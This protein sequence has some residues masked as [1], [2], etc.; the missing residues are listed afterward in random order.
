MNPPNDTPRANYE[1]G[2]LRATVFTATLIQVL[3]S[4]LQRLVPA[5][6]EQSTYLS[7]FW[8]ALTVFITL[9]LCLLGT[10][11]MKPNVDVWAWIAFWVAL[12]VMVLSFI[13]MRIRKNPVQVIVDEILEHNNLE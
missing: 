5:S 6:K 1:F 8:T 9:G 7:V 3:S 10:D 2:N 11:K 12:I 4:Q 13:I